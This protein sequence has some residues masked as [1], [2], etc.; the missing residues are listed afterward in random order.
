M[1]TYKGWLVQYPDLE[2]TWAGELQ[3]TWENPKTGQKEAPI[4]AFFGYPANIFDS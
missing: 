1:F 4:K 3:S 2:G